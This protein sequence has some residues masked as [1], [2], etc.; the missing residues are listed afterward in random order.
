MNPNRGPDKLAH[1]TVREEAF[2]RRVFEGQELHLAYRA[3]FRCAGLSE[4]Q[5]LNNAKAI[6]VKPNVVVRLEQMLND[7]ALIS[8]IDKAR[9][10][11]EMAD[12]AF[13]SAAD[14]VKLNRYCCR[15]CHGFE[16]K[17]QWKDEKEFRDALIDY[18]AAMAS[19]ERL[20]A[21]KK[22]NSKKPVEP[23][24]EGGYEFQRFLPPEPHCPECNGRGVDELEFVP[25]DQ[26]PSRSLK[27]FA[28]AKH[29]RYGIE[30]Q[31][32]SKTDHLRMLADAM[33]LFTKKISVETP[34]GKPLQVN[35][36][37]SA[38]ELANMPIEEL[39][40]LQTLLLKALGPKD[41][42]VV[43]VV[44]KPPRNADPSNVPMVGG[45]EEA[46]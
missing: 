30:Y 18:N 27:L 13:S 25:I 5:I 23:T 20:D 34:D 41:N 32:H 8:S 9:V 26:V 2:V 31:F 7:A 40:T 16:H 29:T 38:A 12:I 4:K 24:D 36:T 44:A 1:L 17:Y 28:G 35:H 39:Q 43:D 22:A 19:W 15:Y 21:N 10:L 42:S 46:T 11:Q 14:F 3:C 37:V 6:L 45:E 33:G